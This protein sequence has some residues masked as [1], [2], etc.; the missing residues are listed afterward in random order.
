MRSTKW[1]R[2]VSS[3]FPFST[4]RYEAEDIFFARHIY[5]CD[6]TVL[7][8]KQVAGEFSLEY[9][10][11]TR[12]PMAFHQAWQYHDSTFV[13]HFMTK[14]LDHNRKTTLSLKDAWV[15]CENGLMCP[16][17]GGKEYLAL[18]IGPNGFR[19]DRD[20]I[21]PMDDPL[22]GLSKKLHIHLVDANCDQTEVS[23]PLR[24]K[25]IV[26]DIRFGE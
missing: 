7:P 24:R 4:N 20:S 23:V 3:T 17:Q 5:D 9:V 10:A 13:E 14:G 19:M 11:T 6:E 12:E 25:R 18:G 2:Y 16:I 1:M 15:Q 21:V 8:S 22:P 26:A